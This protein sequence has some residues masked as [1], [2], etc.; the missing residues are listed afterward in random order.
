MRFPIFTY[1]CLMG[2]LLGCNERIEPEILPDEEVPEKP[3]EPSTDPDDQPPSWP[4]GETGKTYV[5]D[6]E[7]SLS[8]IVDCSGFFCEVVV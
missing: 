8:K 3:S 6:K 5:W 4:E 7:T 1:A 2:L